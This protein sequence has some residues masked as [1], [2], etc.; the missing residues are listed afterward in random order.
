MLLGC[1]V[2]HVSHDLNDRDT[3]T[4]SCACPNAYAPNAH[5]TADNVF[6]SYEG[7]GIGSGKQGRMWRLSRMSGALRVAAESTASASQRVDWPDLEVTPAGGPIAS[8][9]VCTSAGEPGRECA[10]PGPA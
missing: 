6:V 4:D 2:G 9:K 1:L 10:V 7:S 5:E 8:R 3:G